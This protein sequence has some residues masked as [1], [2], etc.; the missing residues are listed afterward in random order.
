[1][2]ILAA[3]KSELSHRGEPI[4]VLFVKGFDDCF[5]K[6][7]MGGRFCYFRTQNLGK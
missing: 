5:R 4:S 3:L 1:M 2:K 6:T 7:A